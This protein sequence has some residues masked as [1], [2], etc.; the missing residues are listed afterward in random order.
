LNNRDIFLIQPDN[1]ISL[2]SSGL[3]QTNGIYKTTIHHIH[4]KL[5]SKME[6]YKRSLKAPVIVKDEPR[7]VIPTEID[8]EIRGLYKELIR[9]QISFNF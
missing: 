2:D 6:E 3:W 7:T 4:E 8:P 1:G 5:H 9:D